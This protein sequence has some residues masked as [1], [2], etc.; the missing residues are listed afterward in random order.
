[1]PCTHSESCPA[2]TWFAED[3]P[4]AATLPRQ[5]IG[6]IR[7]PAL[8]PRLSGR[9]ASRTLEIDSWPF[10]T[11]SKVGWESSWDRLPPEPLNGIL[12]ARTSG[13]FLASF[14]WQKYKSNDMGLF[15]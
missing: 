14:T 2:D 9:I 3:E 8:E 5:R 1:M 15:A 7:P 12:S 6:P 13:Q 10:M 11:P 4:L